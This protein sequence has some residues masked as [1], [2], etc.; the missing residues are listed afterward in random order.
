M[1]SLTGGEWSASHPGSFTPVTHCMEG[2]VDPR[3]SLDEVE[4][5][6]F[7]TLPGLELQPVGRPA[8]IQSLYRLLYPGSKPSRDFV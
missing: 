5:R 2:W 3:T 6:K 8:P 4:K 1:K 7:L